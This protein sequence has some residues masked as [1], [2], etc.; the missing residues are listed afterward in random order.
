MRV[1]A[2]LP[3]V[4]VLV[5]AAAERGE[6]GVAGFARKPVAAKEG[7][8]VRIEFEAKALTDVAVWV[9]DAAGKVVRH[10]V[11]GVL[12]NNPPAP[13]KPGLRQSP[14]W[15]GNDDTGSPAIGG[16]FTV[17]VGLGLKHTFDRSI[18]W[19]PRAVRKIYSLA[20]GPKGEL[21]VLWATPYDVNDP[22]RVM[23][24]SREGRYLR[25]IL[26]YP[27]NL[28]A[29]AMAGI[30][31]IK[32]A[33]GSLAPR[34]YNALGSTYYPWLS[35]IC[36]E[37]MTVSATGR[38]VMLTGWFNYSA[39]ASCGPR[40]LLSVNLDGS[41]PK[42]FA[43]PL[44]ARKRVTGFAHAAASPEGDTIYVSG[45]YLTD[46]WAKKHLP[47]HAVLS[48]S[49]GAGPEADAKTFFGEVGVSGS[50]EKH[51]NDPRGL[52]V[53]S[54][55]SVYV[56]DYG[57]DRI[58]K[59]SNSGAFLGR[60]KVE[61]PDQI[62]INRKS[63]AIYVVSVDHGKH[64]PFHVRGW[65]NKKLL[66]IKG[67]DEPEVVASIDKF[68]GLNTMTIAVDDQA[69]PAVVWIAVAHPNTYHGSGRGLYRCLDEGT[70]FSE[71]TPVLG[72][73]VKSDGLV[74]SLYLAVDPTTERLH[75]RGDKGSNMWY[76]FDGRT[77]RRLPALKLKVVGQERAFDRQGR[78]YCR[79]AIWKKTDGNMVVRY[80]A[81]GSPTPFTGTGSNAIAGLP[82]FMKALPRGMCVA[83][84]GD[85]YLLHYAGDPWKAAGRQTTLTVCGPDGKVKRTGVVTSLRSAAGI[86]VDREGNVYL[87]ENVKPP[88]EPV[89][90][91]LGITPKGRG[92]PWG[93]RADLYDHAG[94]YPWMYGSIVKFGAEGG[95][96]ERAKAGAH[97]TGWPAWSKDRGMVKITGAKW[98]RLGISPVPAVGQACVCM[99]ARFDLDR[100]DRLYVPDAG[101]CRVMVLDSNG[102]EITH[103]GN[104][105][106]VDSAGPGS[107]VQVP[108]I[109][110]AWPGCVATSP[111]A[112]YVSDWLNVRVVRTKPSYAA[113]A[114]CQVP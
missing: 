107:Q 40:R 14:V 41:C 89:P 23:V 43:G 108:D 37:T 66:K 105:G 8:G 18:G 113:E 9:E 53:D 22:P 92:I 68:Q 81:D 56:A 47:S 11:A 45:L 5:L 97:L 103:F 58:V 70:R 109:P 51:L 16:P 98:V 31:P 4:G 30:R 71:P 42:S 50:D 59:L 95:A 80:N 3:A 99:A 2:F 32:L 17:R 76:C 63:G 49:L 21:F 114:S 6:A 15:D 10:V 69:A 85:I 39:S 79:A 19:D 62:A 13:L 33:D 34:V 88:S 74:K 78:V 27:A 46:D 44:L 65:R 12:G 55:G 101:R 82:G 57:N 86:R 72:P 90:A 100:F 77:G 20:V 26:P 91:E 36:R 35:G 29:E 54:E 67:W 104:Y 83:P 73:E 52:A 1:S 24:L 110:L 25:T 96:I 111:E 94:W 48:A 64:I 106:N 7:G 60:I 93:R 102:N 84:N 112:V 28:P 61:N 75:V 87:A 38:L